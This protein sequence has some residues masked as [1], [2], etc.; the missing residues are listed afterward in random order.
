MP[1]ASTQTVRRDGKILTTTRV[2]PGHY[3]LSHQ[4]GG[5]VRWTIRKAQDTGA[6]ERLDEDGRLFSTHGTKAWAIGAARECDNWD[7]D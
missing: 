4:K 5:P 6:W 2:A 3:T 1:T 7:E